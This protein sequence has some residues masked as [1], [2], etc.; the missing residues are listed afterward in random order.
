MQLIPRRMQELRIES[1]ID[2]DIVHPL[3]RGEAAG[4]READV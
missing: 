3:A 2:A 4:K 1:A